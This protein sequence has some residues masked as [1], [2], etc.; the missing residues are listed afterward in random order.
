MFPYYTRSRLSTKQSADQVKH[1][2]APQPLSTM[3]LRTS[4]NVLPLHTF[5]NA[6]LIDI[7][8]EFIRTGACDANFR[9]IAR[10]RTAGLSV[11]LLIRVCVR[12]Y[13]YRVQL[14]VSNYNSSRERCRV[15]DRGKPTS[16]DCSVRV[17]LE[18]ACTFAGHY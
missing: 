2:G 13:K 10:C 17:C 14:R 6:D 9:A 5:F 11:S 15:F 3:L 8:R 12:V 4:R 18:H 1:E 7:S 16:K